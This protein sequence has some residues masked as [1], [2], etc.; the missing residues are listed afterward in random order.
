MMLVKSSAGATPQYG[1]VCAERG[2][3][4]GL[5]AIIV[6]AMVFGARVSV[7]SCVRLPAVYIPGSPRTRS[8]TF[9]LSHQPPGQ[10]GERAY[11]PPLFGQ[12]V[13]VYCYATH[14]SI[15]TMANVL[16]FVLGP[17]APAI[18]APMMV[19]LQSRRLGVDKGIPTVMIASC[20]IA[21]VLCVGSTF[22]GVVVDIRYRIRVHMAGAGALGTLIVP[23]VASIKWQQWSQ[24][25]TLFN[26]YVC[27]VHRPVPHAGVAR[28]GL[29]NVAD[30]V[31][32]DGGMNWREC[33]FAA[34]T[35]L[36]RAAPT[37]A[38]APLYLDMARIASDKEQIAT[39]ITV[40]L[41][42]IAWLM[43]IQ[44]VSMAI[45][46]ILLTAP[47]GALLIKFTASH[48]LH[49]G[50]KVALAEDDKDGYNKRNTTSFDLDKGEE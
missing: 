8:C 10:L 7:R 34:V 2:T 17:V 26:M 49:N 20:S 32:T 46:S 9:A 39:G 27:H 13:A 29:P 33:A 6:L 11:L 1:A 38:L 19:D 50:G 35:W 4:F 47:I 3:L 48:L 5:Y 31:R 22:N 41:F 45:L 16:I 24:T 40:A 25:G 18:V 43:P 21:I 23:L 44:I 12:I 14:H 37:A 28:V 36:P 30:D 15:S 42:V